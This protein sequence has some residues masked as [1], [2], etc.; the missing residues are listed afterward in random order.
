MRSI[1]SK[2]AHKV[3][4]LL[5][6]MEEHLHF[7]VVAIITIKKTRVW[8]L[9]NVHTSRGHQTESKQ[10][11]GARLKVKD[12]FGIKDAWRW[13]ESLQKVNSEEVMGDC[14]TVVCC[15]LLLLYKINGCMHQN[16]IMW[17]YSAVFNS[18]EI[19]LG[20]FWQKFMGKNK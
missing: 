18:P 6:N 1:Y 17:Y 9:K 14:K 5:Q 3:H 11:S 7:N 16:C 15:V 10:S 4:E 2:N 8:D 13:G 12:T 20:I 19:I